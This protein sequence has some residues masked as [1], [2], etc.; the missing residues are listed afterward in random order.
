M[1]QG[2]SYDGQ[3]AEG[4]EPSRLLLLRE[5]SYDVSCFG[6]P[7]LVQYDLV[8]VGSLHCVLHT[9]NSC[10]RQT[11]HYRWGTFVQKDTQG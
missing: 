2:A 5:E 8:D 4:R 1:R 7:Y 9:R 10:G 11:V 3:V 6:S